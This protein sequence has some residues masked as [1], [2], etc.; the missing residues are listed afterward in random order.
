MSGPKNETGVFQGK[1]ILSPE[2]SKI[3][4]A[5][6][7]EEVLRNYNPLGQEM[8]YESGP[9]MVKSM[10]HLTLKT[11]SPDKSYVLMCDGKKIKRGTDIDLPKTKKKGSEMPMKL[12]KRHSSV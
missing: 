2:D 6:L 1:P 7:S 4:F 9:G 11:A 12:L 3:N 8:N 5:C 10:V